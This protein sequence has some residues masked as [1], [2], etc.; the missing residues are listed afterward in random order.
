MHPSGESVRRRNAGK[1]THTAI[2]VLVS[3]TA[4]ALAVPA[5]TS[6]ACT[7]A[8]G[9][10]GTTETFTH[11]GDEQTYVV[12]AGVT[13][14]RATVIGARG[15]NRFGTGGLGGQVDA[16]VDVTAGAT[17]YVLVGGTGEEGSFNGGGS[18]LAADRRRRRFRHSHDLLLA[19]LSRRCRVPHARL[20]PRGRRRRRRNGP[21]RNLR[22]RR[23]SPTERR[24]QRRRPVRQ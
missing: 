19:R 2:R 8:V 21:V 5:E 6:A 1:R 18:G 17:L 3:A 11:C 13:R 14:I 12:P 23:R 7:A 20:T 10:I 15:G 22:R 16:L 4:A 9:A 24:R